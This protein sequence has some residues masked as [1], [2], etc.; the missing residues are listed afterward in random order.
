MNKNLVFTS[1]RLAILCF[2]FLARAGTWDER[3]TFQ[4]VTKEESEQTEKEI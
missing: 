1:H 2:P 3:Q 4:E